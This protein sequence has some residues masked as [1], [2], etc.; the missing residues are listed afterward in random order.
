M[1]KSIQTQHVNKIEKQSNLINKLIV[2]RNRIRKEIAHQKAFIK[3]LEK[4]S[5]KLRTEN[6]ELTIQTVIAKPTNRKDSAGRTEYEAA[7]KRREGWG[8]KCK[9]YNKVREKTLFLLLYLTNLT[10][11][12]LI[13]LKVKDLKQLI[14]EKQISNAWKLVGKK[15]T[16]ELVFQRKDDILALVR[17]KEEDEYAFT[18][19]GSKK[20]IFRTNISNRINQVL[21]EVGEEVGKKLVSTSFL[22]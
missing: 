18:A 8:P 9:E 22:K 12:E 5:Q 10:I 17:H 7:I 11:S 4:Q 1:K 13:R 3:R 6:L 2:E 19:F 14:K 21:K 20:P 16:E 15:A